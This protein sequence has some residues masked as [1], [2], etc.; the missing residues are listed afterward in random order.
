MEGDHGEVSRGE[1]FKPGTGIYLHQLAGNGMEEG[2][3][4]IGDD[5]GIA[6]GDAHRTG[7]RQPAHRAA[8]FAQLL[9]AGCPGGFIGAQGAGAGTAADGIFRGK[10]DQAKKR[11]EDQVGHQKRETAVGTHLCGEAPYICHAY[12]RAYG[13]EDKAPAAGKSGIR[14]LTHFRSSIFQLYFSDIS[15]YITMKSVFCQM[16]FPFG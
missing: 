4:H 2:L 10:A 1:A 8:G 12:S 11:D 6:K 13:G 9:A 7:Q 15:I 16:L 14:F 5:D 3:Q